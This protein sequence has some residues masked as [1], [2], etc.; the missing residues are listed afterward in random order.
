MFQLMNFLKL[1]HGFFFFTFEFYNPQNQ[2]RL[3]KDISKSVVQTKLALSH[4]NP[5]YAPPPFLIGRGSIL[6]DIAC[7]T[8]FKP[9]G[10]GIME[11]LGVNLKHGRYVSFSQ[12]CLCLQSSDF[13]FCVF[14]VEWSLKCLKYSMQSVFCEC[15]PQPSPG[16]HL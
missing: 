15:K 13:N 5:S 2:Q 12:V 9:C 1:P 16:N 10:Q 4:R 7:Q 11:F 14:H 6:K 8:H 3:I